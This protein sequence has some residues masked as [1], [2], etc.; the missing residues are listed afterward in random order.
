ML[1]RAY[2]ALDS[3]RCAE[4]LRR[5]APTVASEESAQKC[6]ARTVNRSPLS[7]GPVLIP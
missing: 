3:R 7:V 6:P 4:A 2:L 5:D 1:R